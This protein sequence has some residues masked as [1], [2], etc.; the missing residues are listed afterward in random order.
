MMIH[1]KGWKAERDRI[2]LLASY[3]AMVKE[4]RVPKSKRLST[5]AISKL[6]NTQLYRASKDLYNGTSTKNAARLAVKMGLADKPKTII[7][8]VKE[9]FFDSDPAKD[10]SHSIAREANRA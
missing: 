7:G 10:E 6:N 1:E 5:E 8:K 3:E 9:F 2:I 4:L